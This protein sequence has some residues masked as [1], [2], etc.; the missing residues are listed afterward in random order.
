MSVLCRSARRVEA[1]VCDRIIADTEVL[2]Q[3]SALTEALVY[4]LSRPAALTG[5]ASS[6]EHF[7]QALARVCPFF[8]E[9]RTND[10]A[11]VDGNGLQKFEENKDGDAGAVGR[12][13]DAYERALVP[14]PPSLQG[15]VWA[16]KVQERVLG[17]RVERCPSVVRGTGVRISRVKEAGRGVVPKGRVVCLYPGTL[18]LP[19]QQPILLQSL[20]NPFI[21]R[22]IDGLLVDGFDKGLSRILFRSCVGRDLV[23]PSPIADA[24]WLTPYPLNPLSVGQYVNNQSKLYRS[25][26]AYQEVTVFPSSMS[27]EKRAYIPNIWS[28]SSVYSPL[29]LVALVTT[30]DVDEGEELFSDYFTLVS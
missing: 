22:C 13:W 1:S 28:K 27:L 19:Q 24:S 9:D 7:Q 20:N 5:R 2:S 12:P 23:G 10:C 3:V 26:V 4:T 14:P 29:R 17:Y 15:H 18:Y 21:F 25:N 6:E 8:E 11:G 16:L 30:R